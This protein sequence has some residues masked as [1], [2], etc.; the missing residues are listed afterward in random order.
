LFLGRYRLAASPYLA[1]IYPKTTICFQPMRR[2]RMGEKGGKKDKNKA[3]KQKQ[4]TVEKKKEQQK[5][6]LPV[7]KP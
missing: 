2:Y 5:N 7:K 3:E 4:S 1:R 6:K